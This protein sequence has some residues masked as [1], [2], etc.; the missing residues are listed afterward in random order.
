MPC[1]CMTFSEQHAPDWDLFWT[2]W[3]CFVIPYS[4]GIFALWIFYTPVW[5]EL[6][7]AGVDATKKDHFARFRISPKYLY[8]R[9]IQKQ[10]AQGL[11]DKIQEMKD[12]LLEEGVHESAF[13]DVG[14]L[15]RGVITALEINGSVDSLAGA[16]FGVIDD[17]N[18]GF[19]DEKEL[20]EGNDKTNDNWVDTAHS[21]MLATLRGYRKTQRDLTKS[22]PHTAAQFPPAGAN[23]PACSVAVLQSWS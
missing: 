18:S 12:M 6:G 23:F 1:E 11:L 21:D 9:V 20:Q 8:E 13:A 16:L 2:M 15:D 19:I 3:L 7:I 14:Q 10:Y 5:G 22:K 17:D 4:I